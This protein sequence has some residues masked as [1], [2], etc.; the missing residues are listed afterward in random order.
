MSYFR[1]MLQGKGKLPVT[2]TSNQHQNMVS[3]IGSNA[4][5][6]KVSVF[7]VDGVDM[8]RLEFGKSS[9]SGID[10]LLYQGPID[11]SDVP[12][13]EVTKFSDTSDVLDFKAA[14]TAS[15]ELHPSDHD[16]SDEATAPTEAVKETTIKE[17]TA[18]EEVAAEVEEAEV[19]GEEEEEVTKIF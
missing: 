8:V 1:G 5:L 18:A 16:N 11:G 14:T 15:K 12:K 13:I 4:G 7:H 10:Q 6:I 17:E 19:K 3:V 9:A 2:K